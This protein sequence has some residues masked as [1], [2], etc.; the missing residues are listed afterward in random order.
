MGECIF[1]NAGNF[2]FDSSQA[3]KNL[4]RI[5]QEPFG[6]QNSSYF[7]P[8]DVDYFDEVLLEG[9]YADRSLSETIGYSV[10]DKKL[11]ATLKE[12]KKPQL[13]LRQ[14]SCQLLQKL[15][16]K[17]VNLVLVATSLD[18]NDVVQKL[19]GS[20]DPGTTSMIPIS[21]NENNNDINNE[22]SGVGSVKIKRENETDFAPNSHRSNQVKNELRSKKTTPHQKDEKYWKR[23]ISNNEAA[24]RSREAKRTRYIWI[25]NRTKELEVENVSLQN[26]LSCLQQKVLALEKTG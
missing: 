5:N 21:F 16:E 24:R 23:R 10:L 25:Q 19:K 20:L 18:E 6:I 7:V 15:R 3:K 14:V 8:T 1:E 13:N 17:R 4:P 11:S 2:M 22:N 12:N 9:H 26:E